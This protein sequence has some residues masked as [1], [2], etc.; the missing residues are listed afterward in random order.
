MMMKRRKN[1]NGLV[2]KPSYKIAKDAIN[3]EATDVQ[4]GPKKE[5][6]DIRLSGRN[7]FT[8]ALSL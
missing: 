8:A 4:V 7:G 1:P 5:N 3:Y 2:D 6:L